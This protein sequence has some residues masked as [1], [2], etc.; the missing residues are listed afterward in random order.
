MIKKLGVFLSF[1]NG[2]YAYPCFVK[3]IDGDRVV[4]TDF[5]ATH[6]DSFLET[7]S[8]LPQTDY[9]GLSGM[10]S[11]YIQITE[12]VG[13]LECLDYIIHWYIE[14]NRNTGFT[15]GSVVLLQNAFELLFNWQMVEKRA[16]Y[17]R[18]QGKGINAAE[19]I[20]ILLRDA[21][22]SLSLPPKYANMDTVL[23]QAGLNYQDFPEL[24]T[25]FR[26]AITH[27]D[28]T[29]RATLSKIQG[30]HRFHIKD[31]GIAFLELLVLYLLDYNGVYASRVS[32]NMFA[33]GNEAQVPWN[34]SC[35]PL[36]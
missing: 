30:I 32:A 27:T 20:R 25:L 4:W 23:K 36:R 2:S 18:A 17:T 28:M 6:A 13:D 14:A 24:F 11:S 34:T 10:W 31:I 35:D 21:G 9:S 19:K 26:N 15:E 1:L 16:I 12:D 22:L 3:G 29:K 33:G 7:S 8:W 5:S